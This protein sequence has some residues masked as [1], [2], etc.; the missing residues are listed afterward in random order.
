[1]S[2]NNGVNQKKSYG[3]YRNDVS[4][5]SETKECSRKKFRALKDDWGVVSD[6][7]HKSA[8]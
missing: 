8:F 5:F 1:M 3:V 6:S 4:R 7:S 2:K